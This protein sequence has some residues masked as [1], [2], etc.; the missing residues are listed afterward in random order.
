MAP[1][2]TRIN[3]PSFRRPFWEELKKS[4]EYLTGVG[5]RTATDFQDMMDIDALDVAPIE[6]HKAATT[7]DGEAPWTCTPG[8]AMIVPIKINCLIARSILFNCEMSLTS[9]LK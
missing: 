5:T 3:D 2:L 6:R 1:L 8:S 7:L 9:I 4:S